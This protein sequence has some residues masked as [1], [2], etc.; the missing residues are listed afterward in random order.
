MNQQ[1][2]Q[3]GN[4]QGNQV[5]EHLGKPITAGSHAAP[6]SL[7][8]V[9]G[10]LPRGYHILVTAAAAMIVVAGMKAFAS[11]IGPVFLALVIVVVASPVHSTLIRRGAPGWVALLGL[12][13]ACFGILLA[14]LGSLVWATAELVTLLASDQYASEMGE[15]QDFA[16][17][18]LDRFGVADESL[19]EIVG[20][21]DLGAVANQISSAVS[22]VLSITSAIGLLV[23]TLLFMV[24]DT[25][26]F[27]TNLRLVAEQRPE[28]ARGLAQFARQTRSYFVI[29]TIFGLVVAGLDVVALEMIGIPLALVWGV[30]SLITNYIP[31][32]GFVIGLIPPALIGYFQ[33]GWKTAVWVIVAYVVINTVIQSVIQPKIVGD[34]LGLSTT[35]TFV[36]LI[37]WGWVIG[38]LGALLAVPMTLLAKA[39]LL[40]IDPSTRWAGPLI[41]LPSSKSVPAAIEPDPEPDPELEGEAEAAEEPIQQDRPT[42]SGAKPEPTDA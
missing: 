2:N 4:Q 25:G 38:P 16:A 41:A 18:Q 7:L 32:V 1:R 40:D 13:A 24:L 3:Q 14:I 35:L 26:R 10:S 39:L 21:L 31:N 28:V 23:I 9:D 6:A 29:S 12:L 30:L 37:F 20:R 11:S 27:S 19:E 34:A 33:G 36:S 42:A 15:I 8:P 22:S 17:E 5:G